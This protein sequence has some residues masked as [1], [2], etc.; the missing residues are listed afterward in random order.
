MSHQAHFAQAI[1]EQ[2]Q[3]ELVAAA[4]Q[5]RLVRLARAAARGR[6]TTPLRPV[7]AAPRGSW[8]DGSAASTPPPEPEVGVT[9][10]CLCHGP[11]AHGPDTS[12][13][14]QPEGVTP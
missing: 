12:S 1:A 5:Y 2:R 6:G 3:A 11:P 4:A 9:A 14:M 10:S 8:S 7:A 13:A